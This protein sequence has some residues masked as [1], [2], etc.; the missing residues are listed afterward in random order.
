MN[1]NVELWKLKQVGAAIW[2]Y[3]NQPLFDEN[4]RMI[5]HMNEFW[6]FYKI[7][8]LEKCWNKKSASQSHYTQ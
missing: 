4:Q 1:V 2:Q 3:L 6:Y 7:R 5:L 8:M